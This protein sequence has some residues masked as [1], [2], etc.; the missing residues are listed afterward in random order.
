MAR[1]SWKSYYVDVDIVR[2]FDELISLA[3][4]QFKEKYKTETSEMSRRFIRENALEISTVAKAFSEEDPIE[5][6]SRNS[7]ILPEFHGFSF[8]VYNGHVFQK[9]LIKQEMLG[10]KFG[11]FAATK[12]IGPKIHYPRKKKKA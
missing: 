11:E 1:S 5:V 10:K 8:L 6:W 12:R 4:L 2:R 3:I 7:V 9:I